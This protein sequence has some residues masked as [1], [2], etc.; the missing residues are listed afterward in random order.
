MSHILRFVH[1][2]SILFVSV[3]QVAFSAS[4][5]AEGEGT[6]GPFDQHT[7]LIYK[8]VVTNIGNSYNSNTGAGDISASMTRFS[9]ID[10]VYLTLTCSTGVFTAPVRGVYH[11]DWHVAQK[12][13]SPHATGVDLM[14]NSGRVF[15]AY[16]QNSSGFGSSSNGVNLFLEL[17]ES[18][19]LRLFRK[20]SVFDNLSHHST[21]SGHLLFPM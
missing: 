3:H 21:F 2:P 14:K 20:T 5:L 1:E 17:G 4:L 11:F 7:P 15:M 12:V 18:V 8:H 10:R 6:T 16:E 13:E 9:L 19:Y